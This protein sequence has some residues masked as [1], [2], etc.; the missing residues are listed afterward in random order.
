MELVCA[1]RNGT[2]SSDQGRR[3]SETGKA[4]ACLGESNGILLLGLWT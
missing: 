3:C 4:T 2:V 1:L